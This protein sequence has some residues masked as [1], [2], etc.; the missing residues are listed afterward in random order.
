M[1]PCKSTSEK[2]SHYAFDCLWKNQQNDCYFWGKTYLKFAILTIAE[3]ILRLSNVFQ[4]VVHLVKVSNKRFSTIFGREM[5][6]RANGLASI[7]IL[8]LSVRSSDAYYQFVPILTWIIPAKILPD[9]M[10]L[11]DHT[12]VVE[13]VT[14]IN[15]PYGNLSK[16]L[17]LKQCIWSLWINDLGLN[18]DFRGLWIDLV[19]P[20]HE[21][22]VWNQT[23]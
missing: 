16:N 10:Q 19:S 4:V 7:Q 18:Q 6:N 22:T 21:Q 23:N 8:V 17:A 5:V 9:R 3:F 20:R 13:T 1:S 2:P 12:K 15:W 11:M 14:V